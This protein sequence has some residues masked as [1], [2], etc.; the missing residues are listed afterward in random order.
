MPHIIV[1]HTTGIDRDLPISG[2]LDKLSACAIGIDALPVG[3]LRI[4]AA[5]RQNARVGDGAAENQFIYIVVRLGQGRTVE[6]K[7]EIGD[8]LFAVLTE[9]TQ[10]YYDEN[11]PLTLG[12]EIQE[13]DADWTWK[14]NNMHQILKDKE[15]G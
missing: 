8:R 5:G 6:V 1:E 12:L 10:S 14:K 11:K 7:K 3:G 4:R 15:N 13:I 9:Y 2:L